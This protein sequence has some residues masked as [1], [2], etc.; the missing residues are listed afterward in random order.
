MDIGELLVD[1]EEGLVSFDDGEHSIDWVSHRIETCDHEEDW[2]I[3][4]E[5]G[6]SLLISQCIESYVG[7]DHAAFSKGLGSDIQYIDL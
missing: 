6:N 2:V 7:Q 4:R 3:A 1:S 5:A